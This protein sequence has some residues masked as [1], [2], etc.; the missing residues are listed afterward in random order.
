M[1]IKSHF[2]AISRAL[3]A[4]CACSLADPEASPGR[5]TTASTEARVRVDHGFAVDRRPAAG[6]AACGRA[7]HRPMLRVGKLT[8]ASGEQQLSK[9]KNL[10][11]GG[12]MAIVA[13]PC[14][15]RR[16]GR[17]SSCRRKRFRRRWCGSATARSGVKFD[18]DV[19]LG[20]LLAGRKPRHGFRASAAAPRH[21]VQGVGPRRQ[22]SITPS[23]CTTF[24][25]AA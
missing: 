8:G 1:S 4:L 11:A 9:I 7:G 6:R 22:D 19:D 2:G 13:Q 10:S 5:S 18:Q 21:R 23:T 3:E 24:R 17:A 15:G 12:L 25:S 14:R 16:A 20:E